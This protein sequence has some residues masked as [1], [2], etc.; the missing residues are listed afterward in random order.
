MQQAKI[1]GDVCFRAGDG[2]MIAAFAAVERVGFH[3][4]AGGEVDGFRRAG[5]DGQAV[6]FEHHRVE[7]G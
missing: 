3:V 5:W 1:R 6:D 2:V 7:G 4:H